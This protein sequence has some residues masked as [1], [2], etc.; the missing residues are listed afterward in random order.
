V[1]LRA[2]RTLVAVADHK[3]LATAAQKLGIQ[4]STLSMQIRML[5]REL[6][7]ALV[8]RTHRP[9]ILTHAALAIVGAARG[10]LAL[11]AGIRRTARADPAIAGDFQIGVIPTATI[12]ILPLAL[13]ALAKTHPRLHV[14]VESGLSDALPTRVLAGDLDAAI[15]TEPDTVDPRLRLRTLFAEPLVLVRPRAWTAARPSEALARH[16]FIH[17]N[18]RAGVGPIIDRFLRHAGIRTHDAMELD[19]IESIL[20]MVASGLGLSIV[21]KFSVTAHHLRAVSVAPLRSRLAVRRVALVVRKD[22]PKGALS[23]AVAA[24]LLTAA[25]N[26]AASFQNI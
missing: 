21:P 13:R 11:E 23:E 17:F 18:P 14:R 6:G 5:E 16:P 26:V 1:N 9:A 10:M 24:A 12:G 19:S 20:A 2:L 4:P 15:V 7:V 22:D 25:A 3:R 8:D